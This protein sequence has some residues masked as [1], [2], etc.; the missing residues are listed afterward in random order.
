LDRISESFV[1]RGGSPLRSMRHATDLA[2]RNHEGHKS[3]EQK[4]RFAGE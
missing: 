3:N 1:L 4:P 2:E